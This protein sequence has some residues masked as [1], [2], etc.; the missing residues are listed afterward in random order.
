MIHDVVGKGCYDMMICMGD[1]ASVYKALIGNLNPIDS[2]FSLPTLAIVFRGL[3]EAC[4]WECV[5]DS[6]CLVDL[7]GTD[8]I[9]QVRDELEIC[10]LGITTLESTDFVNLVQTHK[11][12]TIVY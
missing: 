11:G 3:L 1:M 10:T 4:E 2:P 9:D 7:E 12:N 8:S 6:L 5:C